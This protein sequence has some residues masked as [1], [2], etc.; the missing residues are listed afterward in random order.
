MA[1]AICTR[2]VIA[3][4]GPAGMMLGFLLARAGIDVVVLEKHADFFRDFR[5]DTIHPSTLQLMYELA[6]LDAFLARPHNSRT[7]A[8]CRRTAGSWPSCRSGVRASGP[9][10]VLGRVDYGKMMVMLDRDDYW[11]CAYVIRKGGLAT[12]QTAGI[13]AFRSELRTRCRRSAAPGSTLPCKT[14]SPPRTGS[15]ARSRA[16]C[17]RPATCAPSS[18]LAGIPYLRR[19]PAYFIGVGPR[20][21][22]IGTPERAST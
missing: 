21:E 15:T 2:C 12:L 5:G 17:R 22:H 8:T 4:G 14:P 1:D 19:F 13:E 20:P 9:A 18:V 3:G 10:Q 16:A 6:L 11:Q 7:W